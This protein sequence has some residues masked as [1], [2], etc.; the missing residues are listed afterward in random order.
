MRAGYPVIVYELMWNEGNEN[1]AATEKLSGSKETR[2][3]LKNIV[4]GR[5]YK[6]A[7]RVLNLCGFSELSP[8]LVVRIKGNPPR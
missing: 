7:V 4:P 8:E 6:F 2:F 1:A 5:Y 3:V